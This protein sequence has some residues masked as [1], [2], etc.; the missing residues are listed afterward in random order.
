MQT[1]IT[2][3]LIATCIALTGAS[4]T[5]SSGNHSDNHTNA[6]SAVANAGDA[7]VAA[8][9]DMAHGEVRKVDVD[10]KKITIKHGDIKNL[11]MP[12]MTMVF[13]VKDDALLD[14]LK[15]GDKVRFSAEKLG[16][17]FFVTKIRPA[18]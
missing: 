17:A 6:D 9:A 13:Q 11:D 3:K 5:F 14:K 12:P 15:V 10:N 18:K 7:T 16:S 1:K 2:L 8:P 4:A